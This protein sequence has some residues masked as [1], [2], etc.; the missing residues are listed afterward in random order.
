MSIDK[1]QGL[2]VHISMKKDESWSFLSDWPLPIGIADV[3]IKRTLGTSFIIF[4]STH[5]IPITPLTSSRSSSPAHTTTYIIPIRMPM[6]PPR[7]PIPPCTVHRTKSQQVNSYKNINA[8]MLNMGRPR[9]STCMPCIPCP[10]CIPCIPCPPWGTMAR[11]VSQQQAQARTRT[12]ECLF[13]CA[14]GGGGYRRRCVSQHPA[15]HPER[16]A[17]R[18]RT[19]AAEGSVRLS[20]GRSKIGFSHCGAPRAVATGRAAAAAAVATA[21]VGL[22]GDELSEPGGPVH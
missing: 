12:E 4:D 11:G 16:G 19:S 15:V 6:P 14:C 17:D 20:R 5:Y 9:V 22:E 10:P 1:S 2:P 18:Q 3:L 8:G 7:I 13:M 21:V